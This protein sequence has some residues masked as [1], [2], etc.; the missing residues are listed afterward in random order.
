MTAIP[1]LLNEFNNKSVDICGLSEHWLAP[2]NAYIL[3]N[4]SNNYSAHV[5]T[6]SKVTSGHDRHTGKGGVGFL[7]KSSLD[8]LIEPIMNES[9]RLA[10][11]RVR[12]NDASLFII[13]VYLPCTNHRIDEY[14]AEVD[15]LCDFSASLQ[16]K[17]N[18]ILMG[19]FNAKVH[20]PQ[21]KA[22]ISN[23][24]LYL[25][26][27]LND[28][29]MVVITGS[30]I[31]TG[32][33]YSFLPYNDLNAP[34]L[35]DHF[36]CDELL[37]NNIE[38]CCIERDAPLNVS[39]HLPI[40]ATLKLTTSHNPYANSTITPNLLNRVNYRWND[41]AERNA[42]KTLV[43]S[44]LFNSC[45]STDIDLEYER[46]LNVI[47]YASE[48]CMSKRKY[49]K[50]LKPYW[51][52]AIDELYK[53]M[54]GKR[55]EWIN[56]GKPSN[57]VLKTDYKQIK[58]KFRRTL[59]NAARV[60]EKDELS[61][62]DKLAEVDQKGFWKI[63]NSRKPRKMKPVGCEINFESGLCSE[64]DDLAKGWQMHFQNL[65]SFT[66]DN[67]FDTTFEAYI[68]SK[69]DQYLAENSSNITSD[70]LASQ[71]TENEVYTALKTMPN[72]KAA[73]HDNITYEHIKYAGHQAIALLTRLFNLIIKTEIFPKKL[74]IGVIITIHKGKGKPLKY[75][76]SYRPI[77]LLPVVFKL[78]EKIILNRIEETGLQQRLN[79]LQH[80][81]Q[82][83]KSCTMASFITHEARDFA[84][85]RGSPM[86]CCYLDAKQAFDRV[87]IKGL[88]YKLH[89]LGIRGKMLRIIANMFSDTSSKV[90]VNGVLSDSL[91]LQQGTKQGSIL[92]PFFYTVYID[93]LLNEL[94]K[95]NHGLKLQDIPV[96][97]PTQADDI[98]LLSLSRKGVEELLNIC[99]KYASKWR[100]SYNATKS[101]VVIMN[102]TNK[103]NRKSFPYCN[104]TI[105]CVNSHKHLGITQHTS[106]KIPNIDDVKHSLRASFFTLQH[107]GIH[108]NGINPITATKLYTTIAIPRALYGCELWNALTPT[109][110]TQLETV[111]HFCLK[112]AQNLPR[113]TRSDMVT[114]LVG[115]TSLEAY[116]DYRKLSFLGAL[117]RLRSNDVAFKVFNLRLFQYLSQCTNTN[118]GFI[119]DIYR[120]L[121]KYQLTKYMNDYIKSGKF[122]CKVDWKY[123]CKKGI[124]GYEQMKLVQRMNRSDDFSRFRNIHNSIHPSNLWRVALNYPRYSETIAF[125]V[126]LLTE[127]PEQQICFKCNEMT[128]DILLHLSFDCKFTKQ[129]RQQLNNQL[130]SN[131]GKNFFEFW[132][133]CSKAAQLYYMLGMIDNSVN[134]RLSKHTFPIFITITCRFLFYLYV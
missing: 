77:T 107:S 72:N 90:L 131:F 105:P 65:Y 123:I 84:K 39:R 8:H 42:Y 27:R 128:D 73:S 113:R 16:A 38:H 66:E 125:C 89:E 99:I 25:I 106:G 15:Q 33:K 76:D 96:C 10:A 30:E 70:S 81:F 63:V 29:N 95:S 92:S 5:K 132:T 3:E 121:E 56:A 2:H 54:K 6:C 69:V 55:S 1:Y 91:P 37:V 21:L 13:Q 59:R 22:Q 83:G 134:T 35:I 23:R 60:F 9:D 19:D 94:M 118:H 114:S 53:N 26:N 46:L 18:V 103:T 78:F 71:I 4:I 117:C 51:S 49:N 101:A 11:I 20:N 61:R 80:G 111:H 102:A 124:F 74:K 43:N 12:C 115:C 17:G 34:S 100:Y 45:T 133:K 119:P 120:I 98:V 122:K 112:T 109:T 47:T 57:S 104:S 85:E 24:E 7:W 126:H 97:A 129:H 110:T 44:M 50:H 79:P 88:L 32:P 116:V 93:Q 52:S 41:A 64:I 86:Y 130:Q 62:I 87:W 108:P 28:M 31:C 58:T 67:S 48:T 82:K 14:K 127:V 75:P 68:N 36:I 40:F